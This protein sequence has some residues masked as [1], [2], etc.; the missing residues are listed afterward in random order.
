MWRRRGS[1]TFLVQSLHVKAFFFFWMGPAVLS[2][3][4][5][6]SQR[7]RHRIPLLIYSLASSLHS[8]PLF[9]PQFQNKLDFSPGNSVQGTPLEKEAGRGETALLLVERGKKT[10]IEENRWETK[11]SA[12]ALS[13]VISIPLKQFHP[14]CLPIAAGGVFPDPTGEQSAGISLVS[15]G[16]WALQTSKPWTKCGTT[17]PPGTTL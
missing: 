6:S 1:H 11:A 16:L 12:V 9:Y 4:S 3:H 13:G 10:Y 15:V 14:D 2:I 7:S 8:S 17:D 5:G